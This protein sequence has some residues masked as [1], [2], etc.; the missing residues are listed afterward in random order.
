MQ[1]NLTVFES[2]FNGIGEEKAAMLM[3]LAEAVSANIP[4]GFEAQIQYN[5]P[6]WVVPLS[7]YPAGYHCKSDTP[8]PFI[9]MVAQKNHIAL[10]HMGLYANPKLMDWF[11]IE[12]K[13]CNT[14]KLDMGKSCIRFK[15]GS[16]IPL[17]LIGK[18]CSKMSA[19]A[20]IQLYESAFKK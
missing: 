20:W 3:P 1:H 11:E 6:S 5:M 15:Y 14:K 8:L 19:D 4:E 2:Y 13:S 18:L 12:L 7:L 16:E 17:G 10:Y 9:S